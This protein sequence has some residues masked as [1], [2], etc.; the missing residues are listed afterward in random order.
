MK[1]PKGRRNV[2]AYVL[3]LLLAGGCGGPIWPPFEAIHVGG[4]VPSAQTLPPDMV[5]DDLGLG[6]TGTDSN[7]TMLHPSAML[8]RALSDEG[9]KVTAKSYTRLSLAHHT[10]LITGEYRYILE[11]EIPQGSF[12]DTVTGWRAPDE[13][14]LLARC[15]PLSPMLLDVAPMPAE[16]SP[17]S[18]APSGPGPSSQGPS[19][20]SL[21][22]ASLADA[23][24]RLSLLL[25]RWRKTLSEM[26]EGV[27]KGKTWQER[28]A[29]AMATALPAARP[30]SE[31]DLASRPLAEYHCENVA[32]YL[33][34]AKILLDVG[35]SSKALRE[36]PDPGAV[37]PLLCLFK[38]IGHERLIGLLSDAGAFQQVTRPGHVWRL[39]TWDGVSF[40]VRNLGSRCVRVEVCGGVLRDPVLFPLL[41]GAS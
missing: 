9:G 28:V 15:S 2:A 24:A 34:Y 22:P 10:A 30:L 38:D 17:V 12:R 13:L 7:D 36:M 23:E 11:V 8:V 19:A 14:L 1:S 40:Q 16:R 26:K 4:L 39:T 35:P 18:R 33:M 25:I 31:R 20:T 41:W 3:T 37:G 32:E 29:L 6:Y 27:A 5:R 21:G